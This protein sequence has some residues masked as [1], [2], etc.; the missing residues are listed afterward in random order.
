MGGR[1][2]LG[3]GEGSAGAWSRRAES[4]GSRPLAVA[5]LAKTIITTVAPRAAHNTARLLLP[6]NHTLHR[7]SWDDLR[8]AT[9]SLLV[10][11]VNRHCV[12]G[13]RSVT[14]TS[15]PRL[16]LRILLRW[17]RCPGMGTNWMADRSCKRSFPA[18]GH[19]SYYKSHT[20]R[21]AITCP[22]TGGQERIV[23][24]KRDR[25]TD[26]EVAFVQSQRAGRLATADERGTPHVVPVCYAFDGTRFYTPLDEK[27]KRAGDHAL[28]RVR[29]IV[30]RGEAS[31]VIDQYDDD[32]SRLGYVLVTGRAE[33]IEPGAPGHAAALVLLRERYAQYREMGLE[34]QLVI[35]ITPERVVSWG[36][37]LGKGA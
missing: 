6:A 13:R 35:V 20:T 7:L 23:M 28:R 3:V 29:N 37:A 26:P 19:E 17:L 10:D 27:P 33:L 24:S 4:S 8:R 5:R 1:G 36:P 2:G 11:A 14:L 9:P 18:L 22:S 25:L 12:R 21:A 31:L 32:W 16:R 34:R 15:T 30:A